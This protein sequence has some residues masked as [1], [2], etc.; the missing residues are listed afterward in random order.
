[1]RYTSMFSFENLNL[2]RMQ[3][4]R[5]QLNLVVEVDISISVRTNIP[6]AVLDISKHPI[7]KL[8]VLELIEIARLRYV[9]IDVE[10]G[11]FG[12]HVSEREICP[13]THSS[14]AIRLRRSCLTRW[15]GLKVVKALHHEV[16]YEHSGCDRLKHLPG[17]LWSLLLLL[18]LLLSLN[19]SFSI[20]TL[21]LYSLFY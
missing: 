10:A 7:K 19:I 17:T 4:N 15:L 9:Y 5:S 3:S 1:M 14:I 2:I 13:R 6:I 16:E 18:L 20:L 11:A 8:L 12:E 21:Y